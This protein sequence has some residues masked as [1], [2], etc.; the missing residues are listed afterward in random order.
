MFIIVVCECAV[1]WKSEEDL[2]SYRPPGLALPSLCREQ[3]CVVEEIPHNTTCR[4]SVPAKN[5]SLTNEGWISVSPQSHTCLLP[6][7][8]AACDKC[9]ENSRT[10]IQQVS[11]PWAHNASFSLHTRGIPPE[12]HG[13]QNH[14][15]RHFKGRTSRSFIFLFPFIKGE[16][17][18]VRPC[19]PE[20]LC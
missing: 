12:G 13:S 11:P 4:H 17:N 5:L 6:A 19:H 8:H 10:T 7:W 16:E 1:G 15:S 14:C 3:D 20:G 18:P 9:P 2:P